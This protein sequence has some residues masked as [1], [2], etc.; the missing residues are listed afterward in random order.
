MP[1]PTVYIA[2]DDGGSGSYANTSFKD[3]GYQLVIGA[4][5]DGVNLRYLHL[6]TCME[7]RITSSAQ[8]PM[9][10]LQ[11]GNT[12][13]DHMYR[14]PDEYTVSGVFGIYGA[15]K[16]CKDYDGIPD[17]GNA[18]D[19][20]TNIQNVFEY[21]KDNGI[22]C[23]LTT[24]NEA[25]QGTKRFKQRKSMAL[26]NISWVERQAS[27]QFTL[28]FREI[29][30]VQ[31]KED[32]VI[33]PIEDAPN[34]FLPPAKSLGQILVEGSDGNSAG[35]GSATE[36][37][38]PYAKIVLESLLRN[39]Y[40]ENAVANFLATVGTNIAGY[41]IGFAQIT[42]ILGIGALVGTAGAALL[43]AGAL[44]TVVTAIGGA[45]AAATAVF[46][47]GT[48]I[49]AS[50]AAIL[51]VALLVNHLVQKNKEKARQKKMFKLVNNLDK[52]IDKNGNVDM[53][54]ALKDPAVTI[55]V[56]EMDRLQDF[57]NKVKDRILDTVSNCTFYTISNGQKDNDEREVVL[58]IGNTPYYVMFSKDPTNEF[59]GWKLSVKTAGVG[60]DCSLNGTNGTILHE[61]F[62]P[63]SSFEEMNVNT[64]CLFR[65]ATRKYEVYLY[66]PNLSFEVNPTVDALMNTA[67]YLCGYQLVVSYGHVKDNVDKIYNAI[68]DE[69]IKGGYV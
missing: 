41:G 20:L 37:M 11:N 19:R 29:I 48:I 68:N 2:K 7:K 4:K 65:D 33:K 17:I 5:F 46:P 13:A 1:K 8:I 12:I 18:G 42:L 14:N 54:G 47:V 57:L 49:G 56:D 62:T 51:G 55:N 34:I 21:I 24:I 58:N 59:Y 53:A 23:D 15:N 36:E 67:K 26:Q 25:E 10:P 32:P 69:I 50:V 28:T 63:C 39:G 61:S 64:T 66:N 44:G 40:I 38:S 35:A 43:M 3:R 22:L 16:D 31:V 6:D 45:S 30:A 9:Q 60:G 27:M 52:Y